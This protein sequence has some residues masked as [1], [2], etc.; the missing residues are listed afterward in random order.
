MES[1]KFLF[2]SYDGL[3]A[4]IAWEVVKEEHPAKLWII[5][6]AA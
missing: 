1:K 3:I 4:D 5:G 2:V 6:T